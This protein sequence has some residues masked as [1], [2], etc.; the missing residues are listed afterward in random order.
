MT[1]LVNWVYSSMKGTSLW[2]LKL[3]GIYTKKVSLLIIGLDNAG[4][5]T[6]LGLLA[7]DQI[8]Y[9]EPTYHPN[10]ELV[11]V[12]GIE[13]KAHDLGGHLSARRLWQSYYI[14][15]SCIIFMVDSTDIE[16][17]KESCNEL[18]NILVDVNHIPVLVL[19][20]KNDSQSACSEVELRRYLNLYDI[21]DIDTNIGVFMCSVVNRTG[22]DQAFEWL[23]SKV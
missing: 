16:R 8:K 18:A 9:H 12:G 6:M 20:N 22:I 19:G 7:N 14:N 17:M 21:D 1:S 10:M 23:I 2:F 13:F 11:Q 5:T 4:K 3:S 15:S